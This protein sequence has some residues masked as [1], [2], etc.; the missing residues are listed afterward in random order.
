MRGEYRTIVVRFISR[1]ILM[2]TTS[3]IMVQNH[4]LRW[5]AQK[6]RALYIVIAGGHSVNTSFLSVKSVCIT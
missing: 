1:E 3:G 2:A 5:Y 4:L 6:Y